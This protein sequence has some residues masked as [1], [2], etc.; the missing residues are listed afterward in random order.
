VIGSSRL[1]DLS[2]V[3][4]VLHLSHGGC[5]GTNHAADFQ[6]EDP[7]AARARRVLQ[8]SKPALTRDAY[9]SYM[10]SLARTERYPSS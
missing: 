3:T 9:L 4:P 6:I 10:R 7:E 2:H 5:V 8:T 1:D